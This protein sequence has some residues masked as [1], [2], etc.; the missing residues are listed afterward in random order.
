[1]SD[2][3]HHT[4]HAVPFA[5][6]LAVHLVLV[7]HEV[8]FTIRWERRGERRLIEGDDLAAVNAK[9]KVPTLVLPSGEVLTEIVGVLHHLDEV[10]AGPREPAA[11]RRLIEWLSFIAT[12]VHKQVLA[13]AYDPGVSEEAREDARQRLLPPVLDPLE[14]ALSTRE[15][16]LGGPTPSG[17]DAYAFWS[18]LLLRDLWPEVVA[19]PG[20]TAFRRRM[21]A[22][23]CS[24][25]TLAREQEAMAAVR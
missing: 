18:L 13:P 16:L 10:L 23:S 9:R 12:E 25:R 1:M 4:L 2:Q 7:Q 8:P 15:T 24:R 3:S 19:T 17:A 11:R 22:L 5:C 6:S 21:Q 20:L 14:A